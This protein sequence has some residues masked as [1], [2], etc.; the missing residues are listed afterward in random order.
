MAQHCRIHR[1]PRSQRPHSPA[2]SRRAAADKNAPDRDPLARS[3]ATAAALFETLQQ[4][5]RDLGYVEGQN[6]AFEQRYGDGRARE[7]LHDLAAE[8][9]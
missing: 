5:L 3:Q 9:V 7:R 8:L 6:L 1:H 2:H 4:D